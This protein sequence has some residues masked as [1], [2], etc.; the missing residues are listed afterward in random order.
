MKIVMI[1]ALSA[2]GC[3]A[4]EK[5]D[6]TTW[7]SSEDKIF[8]SK[9]L[10]RYSTYLMGS[11]TYVLHSKSVSPGTL[12]IVLT[13]QPEKYADMS[14][15]GRLEFV[16]LTPEQ[17]VETYSYCG[18]CLLLGGAYTYESFLKSGLVDEVYIT[19]EPIRLENG[20]QLVQDKELDEYLSDFEVEETPLNN[21]GTLL[22]HYKLKK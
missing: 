12:R 7:T 2:N 17:M 1:A 16:D 6:V 13:T 3:I 14:E 4:D 9:T 19:R 21:K 11:K 10:K 20:K 5:G 22:Q 18:E 8:F 15:E